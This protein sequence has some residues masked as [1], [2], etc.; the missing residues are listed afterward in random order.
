MAKARKLGDLSA[1]NRALAHP[2]SRARLMKIIERE[3]NRLRTPSS[4]S[5]QIKQLEQR[6]QN[7][8]NEIADLKTVI[9]SLVD[10]IDELEDK[11]KKEND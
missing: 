1:A 3:T 9:F 11:L 4:K 7:N 10:Y 6:I 8:E 5:K 2:P